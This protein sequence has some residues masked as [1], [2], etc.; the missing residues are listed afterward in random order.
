MRPPTEGRFVQCKASPVTTEN[1]EDDQEQNEKVKFVKFDEGVSRALGVSHHDDVKYKVF[2]LL[3]TINAEH[4]KPLKNSIHM[5]GFDIIRGLV[6][7]TPRQPAP[8]N[9]KHITQRFYDTANG[10]RSFRQNV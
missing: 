10:H 5:R 4:R 3:S 1:D 8:K 2:H 7:V 6:V 9:G